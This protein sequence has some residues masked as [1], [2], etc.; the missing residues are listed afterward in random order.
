MLNPLN[1]IAAEMDSPIL[2]RTVNFE[3]YEQTLTRGSIWLRSDAYYR[4][5]EDEVRRDTGEGF[6]AGT[7]SLP[8]RIP[9][10]SDDGNVQEMLLSGSGKTG[11]FLKPHYIMSMHGSSISVVEREKF[12]GYTLGIRSPGQLSNELSEKAEAH[13]SVVEWVCAQVMYLRPALTL[14]RC[15][16][17]GAP[18]QLGSDTFLSTC[19]RNALWKDP[20]SPF[21]EQDEWRLVIFVDHYLNGDPMAPLKLNVDA[22]NF[23]RYLEPQPILTR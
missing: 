3:V 14:T 10:T 4:A 18:I 5:L 17:G 7:T 20:V 21:I 8:L 12:G 2:F 15:P 16:L 23:Y 6:S 22:S 1:P 9:L 19:G 13:V 11:Q